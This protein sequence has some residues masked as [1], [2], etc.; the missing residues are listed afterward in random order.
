[1]PIVSYRPSAQA[2]AVFVPTPSVDDTMTGSRNP[3]GIATAEPNPPRPPRTSGRRVDA[4]DALMSST[5]RSPAATSTPERAYAA[6]PSVIRPAPIGR[7]TRRAPR[8]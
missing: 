1:M 4:T 5:A 8:A 2:I 3:G 6:R 7:P